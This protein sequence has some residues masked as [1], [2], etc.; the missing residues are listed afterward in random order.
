VKKVVAICWCDQSELSAIHEGLV[1]MAKYWIAPATFGRIDQNS[2]STS[3]SDRDFNSNF[4]LDDHEAQLGLRGPR[5]ELGS[6]QKRAAI[7]GCE[8]GVAPVIG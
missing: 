3:Q 6:A 4:N 1:T 2:K 8:R 5:G 7:R